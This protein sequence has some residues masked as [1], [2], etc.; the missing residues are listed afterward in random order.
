[1]LPANL[2]ASDRISQGRLKR[3]AGRPGPKP[4]RDF[5]PG[6]ALL[7]GVIDL[8]KSR[9]AHGHGLRHDHDGDE[10]AGDGGGPR[11]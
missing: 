6:T 10:I 2:T 9:P 3:M 4:R 5:E 1:M 8:A 7:A 11:M